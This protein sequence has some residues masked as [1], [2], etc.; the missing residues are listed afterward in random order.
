[1]RWIQKQTEPRQ[2]TE[3]R[4]RYSKDI[5]F[6]YNLL[7]QDHDTIKAVHTALLTEQGWLC[8]YTG[9]RIEVQSSHIEHVKPQTHCQESETVTYTNIV[10]CHPAPNQSRKTPYG[11]HQKDNWPQPSEEHLFVSPLDQTCDRRFTYTLKGKIKPQDGD[12]AA[13]ATIIKLGLDHLELEEYRRAAI[14]GTLGKENNLPLKDAKQRLKK[15]QNQT[16]G[17]LEPFCF[18]IVQALEKHINRI[19]AIRI[20]KQSQPKRSKK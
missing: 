15:L 14:Q 20:Q 10:A 2:L 18:A 12:L 17:K 19:E 8:A 5:N 1:M 3:W 13:N 11:A 7:R 6:G 4:S 16:S 9:I